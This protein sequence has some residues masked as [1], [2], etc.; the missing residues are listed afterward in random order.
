MPE[1]SLHN[2]VYSSIKDVPD[3]DIEKFAGFIHAG[4]NAW[5]KAG[6]ILVQMKKVD[7]NI[8]DKI[9]K[10]H[11]AIS[12]E[13]LRR[14]EGIGTRLIYPYLL[15]DNCPGSKKLLSL[16][17]SN[18]VSLYKAQI[19]LVI[20]LK[21]KEPVIV[22]RRIQ[23]LSSFEIERVFDG[24]KI[25]TVKE[26]VQ[27]ILTRLRT[28]DALKRNDLKQ[29]KSEIVCKFCGREN[30]DKCKDNPA[31][32]ELITTLSQC[33]ESLNDLTPAED[34]SHPILRE[35]RKVLKKYK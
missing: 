22:I 33:L 27:F 4:I 1:L 6:E 10:K 30:C 14:F 20:A 2:Q 7:P 8:F 25:R 11:P 18:Q 15:L 5:T 23:Q 26:Q 29:A 31:I 12:Y 16:P 32:C 21:K 28:V 9:Q 13:I 24:S 34:L 3:D 17:Y 35:A 19:E